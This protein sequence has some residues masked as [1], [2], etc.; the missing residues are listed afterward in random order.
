MLQTLFYIPQTIGELPFLGFGLLFGIWAAIAG[1]YLGVKFLRDGWND[2]LQAGLLYSGV[3]GAVII[4]GL[5]MIAEARGIPVRGYGLMMLIAVT[6]SVALAI[7]RARQV[8]LA[9]DVIYSLAMWMILPGIIGARIFFVIEYRDR[10][11]AP[12]MSLGESLV[13]AISL[14]E[15]GLVVFGS[16]IG[17][18]LGL[19]AFTR[20]YRMPLLPLIDVSVP[21]MA[22]GQ[23]IGR[24]GCFFNGCCFGGECDLPWQVTFPPESPPYHQQLEKGKLLLEGLAWQPLKNEDT[25]LIENVQTD[26]AAAK[27]GFVRGQHIVQLRLL[28]SAG[29][30]IERL[31][32]SGKSGQKYLLT[33]D[34]VPLL[35]QATPN[36]QIEAVVSER[37]EPLRWSVRPLPERSLPIHPTQIYSAIDAFI[38]CGFLLAWIPFRKRHGELLALTLILHS[39]SRFLLEIIRIDE[40]SVFGTPWSISQNIS[41]GMFIIGTL[42]LLWINF[43]PRREQMRV[44]RV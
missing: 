10:F 33:Q 41:I 36:S 37:I 16:L 7:H 11:F 26:S 9:D 28:N 8:G 22:L 20:V 1:L 25:L 34:L 15:G 30:E 40:S 5:P 3:I 14:Q 29:N 43:G 6:S 38:L 35:N 44:Q 2:D 31:P 18:V 42:L 4:W 13:K 23:A 19:L 39:I 17:A 21:S 27:L 24:I 12:G 32:A